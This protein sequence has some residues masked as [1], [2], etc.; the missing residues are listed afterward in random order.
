M[1][2]EK[3]A[4]TILRLEGKHNNFKA[5]LSPDTQIREFPGTLL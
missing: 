4:I 2:R 5:Q 1:K 3:V